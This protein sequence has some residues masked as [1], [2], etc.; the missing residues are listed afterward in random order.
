MFIARQACFAHACATSNQLLQ[1]MR[2]APMNRTLPID[3]HSHS[4][5][6]SVCL[7]LSLSLVPPPPPSLSTVHQEPEAV[8]DEIIAFLNA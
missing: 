2:F 5:S 4:H 7:C 6:L 8:L 3:S 1:L